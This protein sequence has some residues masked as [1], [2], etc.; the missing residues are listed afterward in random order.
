[1]H[2]DYSTEF[3]GVAGRVL[4]GTFSFGTFLTGFLAFVPMVALGFV[5]T[6][7]GATN[8][9]SLAVQ[10]VWSLVLAR[11]ALNGLHGE[12]SGWLFSSRGG[13]WLDAGVVGFRFAVLSLVYAVPPIILMAGS[14]AEPAAMSTVGPAGL[15]NPFSTALLL[16]LAVYLL[17]SMFLPPVFL[18]VSVSAESIGDIFSP[19]H[20]RSVFSGR[21][22][23][24]LP[25]YAL[26]VGALATV[27]CIAVP[28]LMGLAAL[29]W[30]LA[31]LLGL[32]V[33]M[34]IIGL[35]ADLLGRLCGFF[36]FGE[37]QLGDAPGSTKDSGGSK[38]P[39]APAPLP[40]NAAAAPDAPVVGA[41]RKAS[42]PLS[43]DPQ[44][45]GTQPMAPGSGKPEIADPR[46]PVEAARQRFGHDPAGAIGSL[47]R[48]REENAPNTLVLHGLCLLQLQHGMQDEA[49]ETG[50]EA[51]KVGVEQGELTLAA[52]VLDKLFSF[53]P[54]FKLTP[55]QMYN[56]ATGL[57][58]REEF[59]VSTKLLAVIIKADPGDTRAVKALMKVG[60]LK[61][62]ARDNQA[63]AKIYS[64][65]LKHCNGSPLDEYIR[66]GLAKAQSSAA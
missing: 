9:M 48:L 38:A 15:A 3:S 5:S 62:N 23:D 51:L 22:G 4:R 55:E 56:L 24:L 58:D 11:Y 30:Q 26:Y 19:A 2:T 54:R 33:L 44:T 8:F 45:P 28:L 6:L 53:L 42:I 57:I 32:V 41:V 34:Y 29:S 36:A 65:L 40:G 60:E 50:R 64:F 1:M 61:L 59:R 52:D 35:S 27:V 18:I 12:F 66:E 43:N 37:A 21:L 47:A 20:W 39:D 10:A 7:T 63:A 49:I 25:L 17:G 16:P 14:S 13:S 46:A 31:A